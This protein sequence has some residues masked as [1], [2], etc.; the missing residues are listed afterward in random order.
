M[1][2][3]VCIMSTNREIRLKDLTHATGQGKLPRRRLRPCVQK[4]LGFIVRPKSANGIT[5]L[6]H[7]CT[8]DT[9]E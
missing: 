2:P 6:P 9:V 4:L 3:A 1:P 5:H 8:G 7:P